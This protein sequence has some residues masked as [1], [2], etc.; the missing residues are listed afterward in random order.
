VCVSVCARVSVR[1]YVVCV[2]VCVCVCVC[3][4]VR[5]C[6]VSC[7]SV[8]VS[9]CMSCVCVF[10][11]F[12]VCVC[13]CVCVS[14]VFFSKRRWLHPSHIMVLSFAQMDRIVRQFSQHAS[15]ALHAALCAIAYV[16]S[17][18]ATPAFHQLVLT[19]TP[20]V[21]ATFPSYAVALYLAAIGAAVSEGVAGDLLSLLASYGQPPPLRESSSVASTAQLFDQLGGYVRGIEAV[22]LSGLKA[23]FAA[24]EVGPDAL[25]DLL[26][27]HNAALACGKASSTDVVGVTLLVSVLALT[28]P[29]AAVQTAALNLLVAL[30]AAVPEV[31]MTAL[32]HVLH[33][34]KQTSEPAEL[35]LLI[36]TLPA[37]CVDP[38]CVTAVIG[39]LVA[40][41]QTPRLIA[42]SL[43]GLHAVWQIDRRA[44]PYLQQVL[45]DR[46][47]IPLELTDE[48]LISRT[49]TMSQVFAENP[50]LGKDFLG[51]LRDV[52]LSGT[53]PTAMAHATEALVSLCESGVLDTENVWAAIRG[54]LLA[55]SRPAVL[56]AAL[57]FVTRLLTPVDA[58]LGDAAAHVDDLV[59]NVKRKELLSLVWS[60]TASTN[61]HVATTA[62]DTLACFHPCALHYTT[63]PSA[64]DPA[65]MIPTVS[66]S[67]PSTYV[68]FLTHARLL[69]TETLTSLLRRRLHW[70][71]D[72][73]PRSQRQQWAQGKFRDASTSVVA[74]DLRA[75]IADQYSNSPQ[76]LVRATMAFPDLL[77]E[78]EFLSLKPASA[79]RSA[80]R[81]LK[82]L[83]GETSVLFSEW[84]QVDLSTRAWEVFM[85]TSFRVFVRARLE[86]ASVTPTSAASKPGPGG[87]VPTA[88]VTG[89][90]QQ[91][92]KSAP[93]APA[94]EAGPTSGPGP[95]TAARAGEA[96]TSSDVALSVSVSAD[97]IAATQARDDLVQELRNALGEADTNTQANS[98]RALAALASGMTATGEA[99]GPAWLERLL[100]TV[101]QL[102]S[103]PTE[104]A[105][106]TSAPLFPAPS[107][108]AG[109]AVLAAAAV[110]A[111]HIACT[112]AERGSPVDSIVLVSVLLFHLRTGFVEGRHTL[113]LS[114][115]RA[116]VRITPL[117][118]SSVLLLEIAG[119]A[120]E[121]LSKPSLSSTVGVSVG[122]VLGATLE[123]LFACQHHESFRQTWVLVA[124]CSLSPSIPLTSAMLGR[125][126]AFVVGLQ[127]ALALQVIEAAD[128]ASFLQALVTC[129]QPQQA[130]EIYALQEVL[131]ELVTR[132]GTNPATAP[133]LNATHKACSPAYIQAHVL[134]EPTFSS[135]SPS[136]RASTLRSLAA[137]VS[138]LNMS[139]SRVTLDPKALPALK[140]SLSVVDAQ[141][142]PALQVL[143]SSLLL[144][145]T[146]SASMPT[147]LDYLPD[148]SLLRSL[149]DF[150]R[151]GCPGAADSVA[152]IGVVLSSLVSHEYLPP[153]DWSGL[154]LHICLA[155]P[156]AAA[157]CLDFALSMLSQSNTMGN[158]VRWCTDPVN[159]LALPIAAQQRLFEQLHAVC[160][161]VGDS[162][163]VLFVNA[164]GPRALQ[165]VHSEIHLAPASEGG[166]AG[167]SR[168]PHG[169]FGKDNE[170]EEDD[171]QSVDL[172]TSAMRGF[173]GCLKRCGDHAPVVAAI[174]ACLL[175]FYAEL[176]LQHMLAAE[177]L[178][179][180]SAPFQLFTQCLSYLPPTE[181]QAI[182]TVGEGST[183]LAALKAAVIVSRM[184][185]FS[186]CPVVWLEPALRWLLCTPTATRS[187]VSDGVDEHPSDSLALDSLIAAELASAFLPVSGSS[188]SSVATQ[189]Q[190][191]DVL[192]IIRSLTLAKAICNVPLCLYF[193]TATFAAIACPS[194]W[195]SLLPILGPT[196]PVFPAPFHARSFEA[197]VS[198]HT[199]QALLL[200]EPLLPRVVQ[201]LSALHALPDSSALSRLFLSLRHLPALA[202]TDFWLLYAQS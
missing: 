180:K 168:P 105:L 29:T 173:H 166:A 176:D 58:I 102:L 117:L 137:C 59:T 151:A 153:V 37:L 75:F 73:F 35:L 83:L 44:W 177:M 20:A 77:L 178:S 144:Q 123:R 55:D 98:V 34:L 74:H 147:S 143:F 135:L 78:E 148:T 104:L 152:T 179:S 4:C 160:L 89:R 36:T 11:V 92:T 56:A 202:L 199:S 76:P 145:D 164:C 17:R 133:L 21:Q 138:A 95:S 193:L 108:H 126:A 142:S 155:R 103:I 43:R 49:F 12:C 181:L 33:S 170:S 66:P 46:G 15:V 7:V 130:Q 94:K 42:L 88:A 149:F 48:V 186:S 114:C 158:F 6:R 60:M 157:H 187:R 109:E 196:K 30:V 65:I 87:S 131:V 127:S 22:Y 8:C 3:V 192:E 110:G 128:V 169:V 121:L 52:V 61:A 80:L 27:R 62:L 139:N 50:D 200:L 119:C 167:E 189:K 39:S 9:V 120:E 18:P 70:E 68:Q 136:A 132:L 19:L 159:F 32:T 86:Q 2:S 115:L 13:V 97:V 41:S 129:A 82:D 163:L 156:A 10:C 47:R 174:R 140:L 161:V 67:P 1:L 113:H 125:A 171:V 93:K 195:P 122:R 190:V 201:C 63:V 191:F 5:V 165:T 69:S 185:R 111:A 99:F 28:H 31:G 150:V 112:L 197:V 106:T 134:S 100:A 23:L 183:T 16:F 81:R 45:L 184:V 72:A 194:A 118:S 64:V 14:A 90:S 54:P 146:A 25:V 154:F 182:V 188:P 38:L 124:S 162:S 107:S 71:L 26:E 79:Q 40:L 24:R 101:Q 51:F 172:R 175:G 91:G 84:C 53:C 85:A 141:T 116:L 96:S 57:I 198:F